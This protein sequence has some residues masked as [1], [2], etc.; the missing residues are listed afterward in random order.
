MDQLTRDPPEY[1]VHPEDPG[2]LFLPADPAG[3][4]HPADLVLPEGPAGPADLPAPCRQTHLLDLPAPHHQD[5]PLDQ[6]VHV[7][8]VFLVGRDFPVRLAAP[9]HRGL[10][11]DLHH[12]EHP[13]DLV[14]R[15]GRT[16]LLVLQ[17]Q[18]SPDHLF[19]LG[20]PVPLSRLLDPAG[21]ADQGSP[22][23]PDNTQY[24]HYYLRYSHT[25]YSCWQNYSYMKSFLSIPFMLSGN[26]LPYY[27]LC[28]PPGFDHLHNKAATGSRIPLLPSCG[29]F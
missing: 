20:G 12:R 5:P 27:I 17:V 19:V 16:Y 21:L 11:L 15:S 18:D 3:Q 4:L 25:A 2:S 24:L 6:L 14:D 13:A 26:L 23:V 28:V 29:S 22:V 10:P 8:L 9:L 7:H 1:P